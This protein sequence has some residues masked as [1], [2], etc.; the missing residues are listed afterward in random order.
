MLKKKSINSVKQLVKAE[1]G[2]E[3]RNYLE[4]ELK[5]N[6]SIVTM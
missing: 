4:N 2:E 5:E 6:C 1:Q 3:G